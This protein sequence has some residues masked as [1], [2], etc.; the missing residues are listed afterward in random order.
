MSGVACMACGGAMSAAEP[1]LFDLP[2]ITSDCRPW[3][4]GRSVATCSGCGLMQRVVYPEVSQYFAKV[5]E[6]YE[7]FKHSATA[8]D[9]INFDA[10]GMGQGRTQKIL[11][12]I[13]KKL[14]QTPKTILDMGSGSGAG[15]LALAGQFPKASIYG[16]EPNDKPSER[17]KFL[18]DNVISIFNTRPSGDKKY[19]L[20]TLFHVFE[21]V[22]DVQDMLAFVLSALTPK[23]HLLIQ[24]PYVAKGAFDLVIADH[25]WHFTKKSLVNL[26]T[27]AN[28]TTV[29]IGNDIIEKELT[30]LTMPGIAADHHLPT[31][32]E[33]QQGQEA[34]DWLVQY[35]SFL[36]E[37]RNTA[38]AV[39]VYGTGPAAAWAGHVLGAKVVA[40]LDDDP[41]RQGSTFN[42]KPVLSPSELEKGMPV[43]AP[44]PDYQAQWIADK[45]KDLNIVLFKR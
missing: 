10:K 18:P 8:S 34:I 24:V 32:D 30:L 3:G 38:N 7:M 19:D 45:N 29:Y 17:Q 6:H 9:Q 33:R 26:L 28:F 1:R 15:L 36:D 40:Y 4:A 42:D 23:G 43:I 5:Y 25:I 12:F 16:F 13:E 20:I 41:A 44:F 2:N 35:K 14:T 37:M 11:S 39:V 22:E 31:V 21:H 27:K